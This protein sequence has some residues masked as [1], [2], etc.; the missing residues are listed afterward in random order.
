[1][2]NHAT[3]RC[4]GGQRAYLHSIYGNCAYES[5]EENQNAPRSCQFRLGMAQTRFKKRI[6]CLHAQHPRLLQCRM[7]TLVLGQHIQ[8]LET[9]PCY[10]HRPSK[11]DL[12]RSSPTWIR[13]PELCI[14]LKSSLYASERESS[15]PSRRSLSKAQSRTTDQLE[16]PI[17]TWLK[18][19]QSTGRSSWRNQAE[20]TVDLSLHYT[21][22]PRYW[23]CCDLPQSPGLLWKRWPVFS[24]IEAVLGSRR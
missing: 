10:H 20:E 11:N 13:C 15:P 2:S 23:R 17:G 14:C 1:M 12:D 6:P 4:L 21:V 9:R 16:E 18:S 19:H 24:K 8:H 7:A 22:A 3:A 5:S